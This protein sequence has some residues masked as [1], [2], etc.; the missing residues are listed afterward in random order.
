MTRYTHTQPAADSGN[1]NPLTPLF[2]IQ[3]VENHDDSGSGTPN[4]PLASVSPPGYNPVSPDSGQGSPAYPWFSMEPTHQ[5]PAQSI[6]ELPADGRYRL[7]ND[8]LE[9]ELRID[10]DGSNIVSGD[11]FAAAAGQREYLASFRSPPGTRLQKG[12]NPLFLVVTDAHRQRADGALQVTQ[13]AGINLLVDLTV[14][15]PVKAL[16]VNQ[17]VSFSGRLEGTA[18]RRLGL[19]IEAEAEVLT[20]P[21][22]EAGGKRISIQSCLEN[23]GF[24][25]YHTGD[26]STIPTPDVQGGWDDSQLHGLM[27]DMARSRL[28]RPD[29]Q[30][31]ALLLQKPKMAGLN[32]VMFDS[33]ERDS[34]RLPRQ[35]F[36][37]FQHE[38]RFPIISRAGDRQVRLDWQRKMIQTVIH[39]LG[40]ALNLA[41]RFERAV[42]RADSSSFMNYDWK[43][44]G[45][46]NR[47]RYWRD[48]NFRF[49]ADELAFL[50]H[51]PHPA[52]IPGGAEFHS[53]PYWENTDGGY[54]PYRRE[55]PTND[56][57]LR[58]LPPAGGGLFRFAQ[59]VLL[60]LVEGWL[61]F[62]SP[63]PTDI[64]INTPYV[65]A[66]VRGTEFV[67]HSRNDR[68]EYAPAAGNQ[69]C[70]ALWV[71]E[72]LVEA[73][74]SKGKL[75]VDGQS[76][77]DRDRTIVALA[78]RPPQ[79]RALA[80][81]PDD[82]VN[83]V[84]Y[85]PPLVRMRGQPPEAPIRK[86]L[87]RIDEG[88]IKGAKELLDERIQTE[89][90]APLHALRSAIALKQNDQ[91]GARKDAERAVAL[92]PGL[93]DAHLALSYVQQAAFDLAAAQISTDL[94]AKSAPDEPLIAA[95]QAEL[96]LSLGDSKFALQRA[97]SAVD[98][99]QAA[100]TTSQYECVADRGTPVGTRDPVLSRAWSVLGFTQLIRLETSLALDSFEN[101]ICADD[102]APLPRLG[103]G[104]GQIRQGD[105][106]TGVQQLELAAALDPRVSLYRSYL[107][108]GYFEQNA[109][110]LAKKELELAKKFDPTD[111]TPWLYDAFRQQVQNDPIG[112]FASL[113]E[114]KA[115]NDQRAVYR[116]RLLLDEDQAAREANLGRV[117]NELGFEKLALLEGAKSTSTDPGNYSGHRLLSDGYA[118]QPRHKI[119]RVSEL[120]QAQLRQ[121][122]N[123]GPIQPQLTETDLFILNGTGPGSVSFNE[124]TSLFNR[125]GT[126]VQA[127]GIAGSNETLGDE[128]VVFGV[129]DRFSYS[130]SQ[131]RYQ[132]DGIQ[133]N[134]DLTTDLL[135]A[136][137]QYRLTPE[138]SVQAEYR[139]RNND[140]GDLFQFFDPNNFLTNLRENNRNRSWRLGLFHAFS[141]NSDVIANVS[142]QDNEIGQHISALY[143]F[144][145]DFEVMDKKKDYQA[146]IQHLF[147]SEN[148]QL[149]SGMGY[150]T[151]DKETFDSFFGT[152]NDNV[153][154]TNV[155]IYAPI[156][157]PDSIVWTVGISADTFNG[158]ITDRDQL[159]PKLGVT[160][161][162]TANTVVRAAGFRTLNRT[163]ISDQTIEPTTIAGF[164]QFFDDPPGTDAWRYGI[165]VDHEI[166]NDLRV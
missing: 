149:T 41:H 158:T 96:A 114:S 90:S 65:T 24:D 61:R 87:N 9:M 128:I 125:N 115:R 63:R 79:H 133:E 135:N 110:K 1:P 28:D 49:D 53:V 102:L 68:C 85:Y 126:S 73:S 113:E 150:F 14:Y 131:Y 159:N 139:Y 104:L 3:P 74:N 71:Q 2:S 162:P 46:N 80:I 164:N 100:G 26:R 105:L 67:I 108:K 35:G 66:G 15:S 13:G 137:A 142:F 120:L 56:F 95:R 62:F 44:L 11:L 6:G 16:P 76:E 112:A 39:E 160:W 81:K 20:T 84:L 127:S 107:G 25:V 130:L 91:A 47:D 7:A 22:W 69:G 144:E 38:I 145:P 31:Q 132:T 12:S 136:F 165:G 123:I 70:A 60:D 18:M 92:D 143:P 121:P 101:A 5:A 88:D 40:H 99:A 148:Y 55:L 146:E 78:G 29:W 153:R 122:N 77:S 42:G 138:T 156:T 82:A 19:E 152:S 155:Y 52:V 51:A 27:T 117:Y 94:A 48:F 43:Y 106:D 72:G 34:N 59:P 93:P 147:R 103:R 111:P 36:A 163:L 75:I 10:L 124:Y 50:R 64:D 151:E 161:S 98:L 157:Y 140:S 58:L 57:T 17:T 86:A 97:R 8:V 37:V 141:P 129:A 83:W 154:H 109:F 33:G 166:S 23:A 134:N 45:G 116:S 30:L 21:N 32:G 118:T 54:V 89:A 119:A 4:I